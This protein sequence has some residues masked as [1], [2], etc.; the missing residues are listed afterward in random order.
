MS[1][2]P[3][4]SQQIPQQQG[5][6][7]FGQGQFGQQQG[8]QGVSTA[9]PQQQQGQQ[10]PGQQMYG[11]G[12]Q[13][14]MGQTGQMGQMLPPQLQQQLQ[15]MGQQQPYQ[16]LLQ[17]LGQQIGAEAIQ[18]GVATRYWNVVDAL[19]GQPPILFL[20]VNNIWRELHN[21]SQI[22]QDVVQRGFIAGHQVIGFFDSANPNSIQAIVVNK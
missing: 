1:T 7:Q 17:Q 19:P 15:Q 6:S 8:Q 10:Q 12:G 21:P 11:Q 16:Q 5:Q 18:S 20:L 4:M 2:T 14:Q 22:V 9:P 3:Q 13:G